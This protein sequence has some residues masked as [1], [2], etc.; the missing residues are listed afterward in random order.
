MAQVDLV[1]KRE[2]VKTD[3]DSIIVTDCFET[4]RGGRTLDVSGFPNK[5]IIAGHPIIKD[6][7][8]YK[9]MPVDGSNANKAV[10]ILTASVAAE[11]PIASIMV[12]GTVNVRAFKET[13]GIDIPEG[14]KTKLNLINFV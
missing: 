8:E 14:V 4:V 9:P 11:K 1:K 12:R 13:S 5:V 7:D 10:G 6:G 2:T 3:N